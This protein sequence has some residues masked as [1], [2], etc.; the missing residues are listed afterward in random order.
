M[1]LCVLTPQRPCAFLLISKGRVLQGLVS[2]R[3]AF[4]AKGKKGGKGWEATARY[5]IFS[6]G[7]FC[8]VFLREEFIYY[9]TAWSS[10]KC[11]RLPTPDTSTRLRIDL[12][13]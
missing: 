1:C 11:K 5:K 9:S 6:G 7:F 13:Q 3:V 4:V 8:F 2:D 12:S 10:C